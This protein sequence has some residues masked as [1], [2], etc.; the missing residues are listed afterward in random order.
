MKLYTEEQVRK[1]LTTKNNLLPVDLFLEIMI[2]IEL[3]TDEKINNRTK[4]LISYNAEIFSRGANW[5][6]EQ[7]KQQQGG[8]YN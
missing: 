6:I 8:R 3:P 7:I 2:P 5:V 1:A 4:G